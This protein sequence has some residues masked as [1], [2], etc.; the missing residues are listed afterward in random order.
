MVNQG[1]SIII[2]GQ[3]YLCAD[4]ITLDGKQYLYLVTASDSIEF[5][6]T[7][8]IEIDGQPQVRIIGDPAEKRQILAAIQAKDEAA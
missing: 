3:E 2:D 6:F 5:C 1:E 7:E 4:Q 8:P